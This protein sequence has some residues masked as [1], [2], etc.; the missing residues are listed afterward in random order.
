MSNEAIAYFNKAVLKYSRGDVKEL[1]S[2]KIRCAGPLLSITMNGIDL[3][4]GIC[5]GFNKGSRARSVAFMATHMNIQSELSSLLYS[6]VRCGVT[7]QGMPKVGV[8]FSLMTERFLPDVIIYRDG[9]ILYLNVTE[10]AFSYLTATERIA[11]NPTSIVLYYPPLQHSDEGAFVNSLSAVKH[12]IS[13]LCG[14][15]E[16][17]IGKKR[18]RGLLAVRLNT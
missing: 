12:D 1:L 11:N 5:F 14:A 2:S 9:N 4:G 8:K 3:M 17:V 10:L 16:Q 7:H 6:C 13:E 18:K 15:V